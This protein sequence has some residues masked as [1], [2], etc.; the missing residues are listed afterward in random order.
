M[1]AEYSPMLSRKLLYGLAVY[2]LPQVSIAETY[3]E[4]LIRVTKTANENMTL[5][6]LRELCA[7]SA[8]TEISVFEARY[9][10]EEATKNNRFIITPHNPNYVLPVSYSSR[11]N[12]APYQASKFADNLSH[13]EIKFQ[14][15]LKAPVTRNLFGQ[16]GELWFA[17]TNT[18]WWQA[19][20]DESAPFRETNHE[21]EL[22]FMFPATATIL[23]MNL[24]FIMLGASH[25][26]NGRGGDL[27]R[28]WNRLFA[29]FIFSKDNFAF[30][31]KPWWRIPEP[32]K[33]NENSAKGDDNP[34]IEKYM[35]YGEL[36]MAYTI[37]KHNLAIMLRNNLRKDNKGAIQIDWSFPINKRFRGY[38]QYFNGYGE[39]LI[40]YNHYSN[41]YSLG[42][43]LTDWL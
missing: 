21:P 28:S 20:N 13:T 19:Y 29:N 22:F 35:G 11:P 16:G 26:S 6:A 9:E 33:D 31:F 15:S 27:S 14:L 42:I 3:N 18:S 23:D 38:F 34:D 32:A 43:M 8:V 40:D 12:S 36:G 1:N 41:R 5:K 25:Q 30:S 4:C 37:D 24:D 10:K 39:S 7:Q 17:Y 2:L